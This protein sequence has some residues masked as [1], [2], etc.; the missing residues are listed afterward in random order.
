MCS[1]RRALSEKNIAVPQGAC[2]KP[3]PLSLWEFGGLIGKQA[4]KRGLSNLSASPLETVVETVLAFILKPC[5][6][7]LVYRRRERPQNLNF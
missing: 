3:S 2:E 4:V 6:Y 1:P 7:G 5:P